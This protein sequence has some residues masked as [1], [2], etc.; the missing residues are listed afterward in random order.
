MKPANHT[1]DRFPKK[2]IKYIWTRNIVHFPQGSN[3]VNLKFDY[4]FHCRKINAC[5]F[6]LRLTVL[7]CG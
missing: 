2:D 4:K 7:G 3:F 6:T 5:C 1:M